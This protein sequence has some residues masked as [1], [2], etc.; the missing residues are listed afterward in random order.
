M[1]GQ[2]VIDHLGHAFP[3]CQF[4]SLGQ[5]DDRHP[6]PDVFGGFLQHFAKM[7]GGN[8]HD[9]HVTVRNRLR[10]TVRGG[11]FAVERRPR[12]IL[13]VP[14]A[15]V[16][17]LDGILAASPNFYRSIASDQGGDGRAPGAPPPSNPAFRFI[18]LP[19]LSFEPDYQ[20]F[21]QEP[22]RFFFFSF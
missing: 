18:R 8:P 16:D 15:A 21:W 5:A 1:A 17:F 13:A 7:L 22:Q 6:G 10:D 11:Q 4:Q 12:K 9:Q 2:D 14:L 3:G 20:S 19:R